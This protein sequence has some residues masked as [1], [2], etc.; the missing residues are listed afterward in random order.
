MD[1]SYKTVY[2]E[3][4]GEILAKK[5]KFIGSVFPIESE[6]AA[7]NRIE[8]TKKKYQDANHNCFAY[9]AGLN[10]EYIRCSDDGEPAKTAGKPILDII[11]NEN[12]HNCLII[13]TRY[14]G[15][16]LLGTGGL[17]HAY[18]SAAKAG[19]EASVIIE[20]KTGY[21][22]Q[23]ITDYNSIGKLQYIFA[24]MGIMTI[25]NEFTHIVTTDLVVPASVYEN[26]EFNIME[27]TGGQIQIT[28]KQDCYYA[29]KDNQ[30]LIFK[31]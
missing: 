29:T 16:T 15:G 19:L 27:A 8:V 22:L 25:S 28:N 3:G 24:Q 13:V 26:F 21:Q 11:L 31:E 9:V 18:Q 30:V 14:F 5:S 7:L 6:E 4:F 20:K 1:H 10:N 23:V 12:I 17:V 2:T